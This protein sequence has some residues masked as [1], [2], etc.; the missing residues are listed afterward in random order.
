MTTNIPRTCQ[1]TVHQVPIKYAPLDTD[2]FYAS[3]TYDFSS[4]GLCYES[5]G[6]L[7]PGTDVCIVM[8]NYRPG[9][10]GPEGYRSYVASIRWTQPL[11]KNGTER[12]ASGA[13]LIFRSHDI[14]RTENQL[15]HHVCDLCGAQKPLNKID[16]TQAGAQLC[17]HCMKHYCCIPLGKIRQCV[18]RF[19]LG[20]VV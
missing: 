5:D 18:D 19:L 4:G 14:I 17:A 16:S 2:T 12:Y 9:Q 20:N 6:P 11:S 1:R 15:P 13:R 8:E 3:R 10:S 7:T